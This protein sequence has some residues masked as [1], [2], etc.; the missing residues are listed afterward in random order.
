MHEIVNAFFASQ[1]FSSALDIMAND[2]VYNIIQCSVKGFTN[3][4]LNMIEKQDRR[5]TDTVCNAFVL[6]GHSNVSVVKDSL[7]SFS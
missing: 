2:N 7:S 6:V 1:F 4:M 5:H 3:S